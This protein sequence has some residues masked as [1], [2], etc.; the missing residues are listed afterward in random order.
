MI[1]ML[2]DCGRWRV[3]GGSTN[4]PSCYRGIAISSCLSKLFTRI[5]FNRLEKYLENNNIICPEQIGFKRGARISDHIFTLESLIDNFFKNNKYLFACFV[6]LKKAFDTVN[7]QALLF[8]LNRYNIRG[9]FLNIIED[10]YN[11]VSFSIRLA[12][13]ITQPFQTSIGVKQGCILSSTFFSVYMNDLVE[14]FNLECDSVSIDG[15]SISCLLY[16]DDIVLMSQS[17]NGLQKLLDNLKLFCDQWNLK[18]NIQ[19]TKVMIFNK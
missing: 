3:P 10:M 6:D 17:A 11:D 9:H 13:G 18:V 7:R 14:H 19:K 1:C 16:A 5:L 12:N 15:K 8:N 4:D 2:A